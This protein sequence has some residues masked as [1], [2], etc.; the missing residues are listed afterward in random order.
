VKNTQVRLDVETA[1]TLREI[2]AAFEYYTERGIG[3]G[4]IGN[5]AAIL[6]R[7]ADEY[8]RDPA[9][10]LLALGFILVKP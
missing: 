10:T 1:R 4:E 3:A 2:A 9:G 6:K 8:K 7:L 5:T